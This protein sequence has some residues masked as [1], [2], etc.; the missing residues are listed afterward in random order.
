MKKYLFVGD[1]HADLDF[2]ANAAAMAAEHDATMIVLGD[3]G[4]IWPKSNQVASLA[5][6]LKLA[7]EREARDPVTMRFIDGNHD[8]HPVLRRYLD[9]KES[10]PMKDAEGKPHANIIYQSR[11]SVYEDEDGTR[12]LFVGGAPSIDRASRTEGLSWWPEETM[13]EEEFQKALD[14]EGPIHVL[15][16]H[17]APDL[18]PGYEPKGFPEF[19]KRAARSMAM[20]F[21]LIEKHRPELHV[22]GHWH[23][24]YRRPNG[25][26]TLTVGLDCNYAR[27]PEAV[28]LWEREP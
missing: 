7:G 20:V 6:E 23:T 12:F 25:N 16:T 3:W 24:W 8:W 2:A 14:V 5:R 27:F 28:Y 4:F 13:T 15:V 26:G 9:G 17:D 21:S 22:H 19:R 10:G 18:P 1:T 11:G